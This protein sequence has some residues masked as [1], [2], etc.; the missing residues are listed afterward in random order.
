LSELRIRA[1]NAADANAIARVHVQAWHESYR[2]LVA[3]EVLA[4]LSVERNTQMWR[5]VLDGAEGSIVHVVER[6]NEIVGFG[7]AGRARSPLLGTG[8]EIMAIYLLD[9][10][11]RGGLGRRLLAGLFGA[12]AAQGHGSAGL[13]VLIDNHGTRRFYEAMGG[14]TGAE[15]ELG[16]PIAMR[17]IAYVWDD[18]AAFRVS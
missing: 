3:N 11:K 15:R 18:L 8:S 12:L 7:S 13:W 2:G 1:A 9:A 5:A 4:A 14:R 10:V 16:P 17:E 6:E